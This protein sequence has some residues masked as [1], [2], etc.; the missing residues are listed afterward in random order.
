MVSAELP[1]L[2]WVQHYDPTPLSHSGFCQ[3][4]YSPAQYPFLVEFATVQP[5]GQSPGHGSSL[6]IGLTL[7]SL[8][9]KST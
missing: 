4:R 3:T 6:P 5:V 2:C 9:N 7:C 1:A 8:A